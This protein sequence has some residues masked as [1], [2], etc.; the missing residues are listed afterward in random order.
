[1]NT[2]EVSRRSFIKKAT[3]LSAAA[4]AMPTILTSV[5]GSAKAAAP[6]RVSA[7]DRVNLALVGIGY[8]G[9]ADAQQ[10]MRS[11]LCNIVALCDV[12][13]GAPHTLDIMNA[14]PNAPRFN[15][16]RQMF[17]KM[18]NQIDAVQV[19]TPDHSHF[20]VAMHAMKLG[21][22]VY[23]EKP[24]ART[25]LECELLMEAE[26]KY[27]VVT[28][29]GN[30]GHS[31]E[32]YWQFKAWTEAGIIKNVTSV[33]AH[34]NQDRRWHPWNSKMTSYLP[35]EPVPPT[36]NWD[37]WMAAT[38]PRAY[39]KDYHPGQWRGWYEYG[40]G[41][42]GDWGAHLIDTVHEFLKLGLPYEVDPTYLLEHNP[43]F[44]PM[45]S[46]LIFKFPE[47]TASGGP[48][49][50]GGGGGPRGS[51]NLPACTISWYDGIDN[52]APVP[53][54]FGGSVRQDADIPPP[55]GVQQPQRTRRPATGKEI[56]SETLNFKG[57]SHAAPLSIFPDE[58]AK[59]MEKNLPKVPPP[60][61]NHYENFLKACLGLERAN[62]PFSVSGLLA[63]TFCL[64]V[65]AQWTGKKVV[66]DR[67]TKQII[68]NPQANQM[69][70]G[71]VP[72]KEYVHY[73]G[74]V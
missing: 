55:G 16:F 2:N 45:S 22:H 58:K 42:L 64:G 49:V 70:W 51:S 61:S 73:Y 68:N 50:S 56:F 14:C 23:V 74:V 66:F 6:K 37:A 48:V 1:M 54:G 19:A 31:G 63:Q 18:G 72:R 38:H 3:A 34:M 60:P 28:Q 12:D 67:E 43:F 8:Q 47:R 17:D 10:F 62:S 59:E 25:F 39:N 30:Q 24:L 27:G 52:F 36:M 4:S 29:M 5:Q 26:R 53:E 40:T 69:L 21:K 71:Q 35:G 41:C 15:D 44:F 9:Q 57:G 46:T 65:A 7:S 32:N 33:V 20:V 13:M 11:G